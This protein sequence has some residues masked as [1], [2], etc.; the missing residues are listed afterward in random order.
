MENHYSNLSTKSPQFT[1]SF[2]LDAKL[3]KAVRWIC[4]LLMRTCHTLKYRTQF[5]LK[6]GLN[7]LEVLSRENLSWWAKQIKIKRVDNRSTALWLNPP[8]V[9]LLLPSSLPVQHISM[10][11]W[12]AVSSTSC[13]LITAHGK[14]Y[15]PVPWLSFSAMCSHHLP[16]PSPLSAP[17]VS[18]GSAPGTSLGHWL[19]VPVNCP[20][21]GQDRIH[22][23]TLPDT[24]LYTTSANTPTGYTVY[25]PH[26]HKIQHAMKKNT[27]KEFKYLLE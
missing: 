27:L 16:H 23:L 15:L 24:P 25:L 13:S 1:R 19:A 3:A 6:V 10:A 9:K 14:R 12:F 11:S 26:V 8:W 2:S 4:L 18:P 21:A 5:Y 20:G 17:A 7:R 22:L